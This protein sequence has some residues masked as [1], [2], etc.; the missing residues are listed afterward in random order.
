MH[1]IITIIAAVVVKITVV[2]IDESVI[3][4]T[5]AT[6]ATAIAI[7]AVQVLI[8]N[9]VDLVKSQI[10]FDWRNLHFEIQAFR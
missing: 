8:R 3:T 6:T 4:V 9:K 5:I 10:V 7:F 2:A 1:C